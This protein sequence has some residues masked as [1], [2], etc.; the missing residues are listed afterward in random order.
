MGVLVTMYDSRKSI[1]KE[2]RNNLEDT[3]RNK[4]FES[5]IRINT[6]IEKSQESQTPVIFFDKTCNGY[7]DYMN[8]A[9]EVINYER[10]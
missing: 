6:Q 1:S 4:V 5:V 8:L 10:K 2:I 7:I 9:K 3:F